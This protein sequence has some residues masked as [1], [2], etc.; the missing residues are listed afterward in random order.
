[1]QTLVYTPVVLVPEAEKLRQRFEGN[2]TGADATTEE[3]LKKQLFLG[4]RR[5][6]SA[7]DFGSYHA[8]EFRRSV[9]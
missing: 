5:L 6:V 4:R 8:R 2:F 7:N 9:P 1:M 3:G